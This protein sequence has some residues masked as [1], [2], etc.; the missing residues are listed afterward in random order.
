MM[1]NSYISTIMNMSADIYE[2]E[3][4]Q[5]SDTGAIDRHWE[6]RK[7]VKCLIHP[8]KNS[9]TALTADGKEF[10]MGAN[11]YGEVLQ[12]RAKFPIRLSKR[13]RVSGIK[14]ANGQYIYVEPDLYSM[15]ST[16][17]E[18]MACHPMVDPFGKL[19]HYDVILERSL[20]QLNDNFKN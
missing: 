18:V 17:F 2:Q 12:L 9:G 7:T 6:Y 20:V 15:P 16:V 14:A 8:S 13:W 11:G 4:T 19:S 10:R 5:N 3:N 1:L